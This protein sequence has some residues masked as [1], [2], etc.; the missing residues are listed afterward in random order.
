M[1]DRGNGEGSE[2]G[3]QVYS[4][5]GQDGSGVG[6]RSGRKEREE[7]HYSILQKDGCQVSLGQ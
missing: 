2:K 3:H 4:I 5:R 1:I 7:C 6:M